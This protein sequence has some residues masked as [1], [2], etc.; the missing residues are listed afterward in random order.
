MTT[1]PM[2]VV[3][4]RSNP[5]QARSEGILLGIGDPGLELRVVSEVLAPAH[6]PQR[7][8]QDTG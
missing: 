3:P 2:R 7:R 1:L 5:M 4:V 6:A 8:K